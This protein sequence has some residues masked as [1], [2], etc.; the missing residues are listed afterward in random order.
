MHSGLPAEQLERRSDR[1]V[2]WLGMRSA[3]LVNMCRRH[4]EARGPDFEFEVLAVV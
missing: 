3:P 1:P 2:E 4:F